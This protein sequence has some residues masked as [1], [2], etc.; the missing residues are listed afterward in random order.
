MYF[1]II[2]VNRTV[3]FKRAISP[4][5]L[6]S[7]VKLWG[8]RVFVT[9]IAPETV[10]VAEETVVLAEINVRTLV[11]VVSE[12][13]ELQSNVSTTKMILIK[14]IDQ[15]IRH[16]FTVKFIPRYN[17]FQKYLDRNK[18]DYVLFYREIK[19]PALIML[20][21]NIFNQSENNIQVI[22]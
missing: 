20:V 5:E 22:R 17:Y 13:I 14:G 2:E 11:T 9:S 3:S 21:H 6:R 10:I 7:D 8:E 19:Q 4:R 15:R 12:R 16:C 1:F 18:F